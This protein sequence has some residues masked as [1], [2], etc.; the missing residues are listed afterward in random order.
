MI[1]GIVGAEA[2]KFTFTGQ[3]RARFAIRELLANFQPDLV[4]S[5]ECHLGGVDIWA[6]QEAK[7]AG[8]PFQ[9]YPPDVFSWASFRVRNL[10]IAETST[11][12]FCLPVTRYIVGYQYEQFPSCYHCV[13]AGETGDDHVKSGGCWTMH[14]A[15]KLGKLWGRIDIEP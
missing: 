15:R 6:K 8:I 2:V 4:V 14:E 11:A 3:Q 12:V 7:A 13:R 1:L 9:G 10:R 5:G